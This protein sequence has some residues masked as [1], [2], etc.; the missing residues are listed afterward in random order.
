TASKGKAGEALVTS[1]RLADVNDVAV[2]FEWSA[3]TGRATRCV[4]TERHIYRTPAGGR[5]QANT[6]EPI[7]KQRTTQPEAQPVPLAFALLP[8]I[9]VTGIVAGKS[10]PA[11]FVSETYIAEQFQL[12]DGGR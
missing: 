10:A 8:I 12:A 11:V 6:E 3:A 7:I 4:V 2:F 1:V 5:L 9:W